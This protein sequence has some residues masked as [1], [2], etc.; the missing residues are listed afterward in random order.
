MKKKL[1]ALFLIVS[2]VIS[3]A[4]CGSGGSDGEN[5][6][7]ISSELTFDH[8][9]ELKYAREF[10]VD[11]YQDGFALLTIAKDGRYLVVPEG[12]TAPEDLKDDIVVLQKPLDHIYLAASAVMDMF[13]KMDALD[14]IRFSAL[15]Q[16]SWYIGEIRQVMEQ[17]DI[18]YAGSYSAPDYEK[19]L[20]EQ[21]SLA[22]ENTMIYHTPEVKEQL[23][24]FGI[25]VLVDYSSYESE[26]LGRTEWVRLYGLLTDREEAADAA[27]EEQVKA[28][29]EIS[30][31]EPSGKTVAFF[32]ITSNGE[33]NVR[34]SSD[35]LPTMIEMAGGSY[36]FD[37]VGDE[38]SATSTVSLPMEEFYVGAKDADYV[39]YNSTIDGELSSIDDLL[40]KSSLLSN[41]KAVQEG[42]VY[43][44]T[45]NL[46]QSSMELGTIISDLHKMMAGDDSSLTYLYRL[47]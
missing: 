23:T 10:S 12:K 41:L 26:P 37:H 29:E 3:M 40:A 30:E 15:K 11:Y 34:S 18:L 7:E 19:I 45:K 27:F 21:C 25:P 47:E 31:A 8:S 28:F 17:G 5:S 4:A 43:C 2:M 13:L 35:Y 24:K 1:T 44:T 46:Y 32:Y 22:I 9:M 16:N 36:V 38:D 14:T 39:V 20:A 42:N 6:T 33:V